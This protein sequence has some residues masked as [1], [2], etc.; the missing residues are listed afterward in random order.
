MKLRSPAVE[1]LQTAETERT[2]RTS[3]A[4]LNATREAES[5]L[6]GFGQL[7]K[8]HGLEISE[9]VGEC[10][11]AFASSTLVQMRT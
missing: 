3:V 4:T 10:C 9:E 1:T 11:C 2:R 8:M 5:K 7:L 6:P